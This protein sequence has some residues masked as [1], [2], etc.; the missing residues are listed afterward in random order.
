MCDAPASDLFDLT[1]FE[2]LSTLRRSILL[3]LLSLLILFKLLEIVIIGDFFDLDLTELSHAS[4]S[5]KA[6]S[7]DFILDLL[8]S[9]VEVFDA[10]TCRDVPSL[11]EGKDL[12]KARLVI[13]AF[14]N[15]LL[16]EVNN[17][18][19]YRGMGILGFLGISI[20]LRSFG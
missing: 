6:E 12:S 11:G 13:E 16:I 19:V 5:M 8:L 17:E 20:V 10:E 14:S 1:I 3:A 4:C 2:S 7:I 18:R 9:G 15:G